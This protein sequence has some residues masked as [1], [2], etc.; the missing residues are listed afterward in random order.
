MPAGGLLARFLAPVRRASDIVY[1]ALLLVL[2]S[3]VYITVIPL[4]AVALR[5]RR[6]RSPGWLLRDDARLASID[7]LR[8]PF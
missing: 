3:L 2:L 5:M 8:S 6:R 7:R 1:R 4:Y